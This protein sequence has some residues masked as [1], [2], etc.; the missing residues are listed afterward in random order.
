MT[1]LNSQAL[2]ELNKKLNLLPEGVEVVI[3][4]DMDGVLAQ[5][6]KACNPEIIYEKDYFYN[7]L[8]E[9]CM[10]EALLHL[11]HA[12]FKVSILSAAAVDG[13]ARGDKSRWLEKHGMKELPRLYSPLGHNKT[14]SI[15]VKP[16][17]VYVL[18]DDFNPNLIGWGQTDVEGAKFVAIKFLNGINGG[19]D[20][21]QGQTIYHRSSGIAIA[22]E[23]ADA[24]VMAA[25][26]MNK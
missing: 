9:P 24:A 15:E 5:W 6:D 21:W 16:N 1:N 19:S 23:L 7:L 3:Y 17:T 26:T 20:T 4:C 13:Y 22:Y 8:L 2:I 14:D 11:H 10:K 12:G 18:L 25:L